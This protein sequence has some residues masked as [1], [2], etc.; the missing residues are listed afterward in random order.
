MMRRHTHRALSLLALTLLSA[1]S[2]ETAAVAS[3]DMGDM[4]DPAAPRHDGDVCEQAL[5]VTC[6]QFAEAYL[7]GIPQPRVRQVR[8]RR[9][10]RG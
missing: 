8:R 1:C 6:G 3:W 9:G 5:G 2:E 4:V 7:K 10:A